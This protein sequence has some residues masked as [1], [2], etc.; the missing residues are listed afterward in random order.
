MKLLAFI[1]AIPSALHWCLA[2]VLYYVAYPFAG[3]DRRVI[4]SNV[5]KVYKLPAHSEFS[6]LFVKQNL[7]TQLLIMFETIKYVFR[8]QEL[9][10]VGMEEARAILEPASKDSSVVII[11][12]HIGSWELAGH[13]AAVC[14][15]RPFHVL[16]KPSKSKWVT[17]VLNS[18]RER[19]GMKVLWTDSKTLL[20]EMMAVSQ[21]HE[22]LGFVMDQRPGNKQ[23]GYPSVFLGV[24]GTNIVSGP[25][26]MAVKRNLPV[27]GVYMM[28]TGRCTYRFYVTEVLPKNHQITD[29]AKVAQLMADDM[30]KMI[31]LYPEQWAWN[32]RRWK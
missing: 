1:A 20:R 16:A 24:E 9:Q 14:F 29:D 3:R 30:S 13:A 21:S 2:V 31:R 22:H 5:D 28:R 15:D 23:G 8:P 11:A 7:R 4:Q 12:A 18:L 25:V 26:M 10:I 17:P 19:L 6:K 27:C 32:Y